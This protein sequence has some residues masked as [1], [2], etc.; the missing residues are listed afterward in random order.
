MAHL[1]NFLR[2]TWYSWRLEQ[3]AP[4]DPPQCPVILIPGILGSALS[5][6]GQRRLVWGDVPSFYRP[7]G[8]GRALRV[9]LAG[10]PPPV[11]VHGPIT[12]ITLIPGL[13]QMPV[14]RDLVWFLTR[15][16]GYRLRGPTPTLYLHGYDFRLDLADSVLALA[17]FMSGLRAGRPTRF[18]LLGHSFGGVV[19]SALARWGTP[20]FP[21]A[22]SWVAG[23][24]S[25]AAGF[26]GAVDN[27]RLMV[28]GYRPAPGGI[29]LD[30]ATILCGRS[31]VESLPSPDV[32][33]FADE[34]GRALS[35]DLYDPETWIRYQLGIF[36]RSQ[37]LLSDRDAWVEFLAV[38]LKRAL[39][40]HQL[41]QKPL[42]DSTAPHVSIGGGQLETLDRA[43]LVAHSSHWQCLF[44][45]RSQAGR[46]L[47]NAAAAR[48]FVAGDG[49]VP[50][51]SLA[52]WNG[53]GSA[54]VELVPGAHRV[55]INK[56]PLW[57]AV[58]RALQS[59][60]SGGR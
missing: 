23:V 6:P 38:S 42:P 8:G 30:P 46:T 35:A 37:P 17:R 29:T 12:G 44:P 52:R 16:R 9:P 1:L 55:L 11:A 14:Y 20:E 47:G 13:W 5:E 28:D 34:Q 18:I 56:P 43:V 48:L 59:L 32:P 58:A 33:A 3:S 39:N 21:E 15:T 26:G 19:A 10:N 49:E 22:R 50:V 57:L 45:T 31:S 36:A 27:L 24:V 40:V 25:M 7:P 2:E 51:H 53:A 60:E 54:P 4:A 41:L